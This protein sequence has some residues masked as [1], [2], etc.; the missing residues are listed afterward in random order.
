MQKL[1]QGE[2]SL[3]QV[4]AEIKSAGYDSVFLVT[5][6]HFLKENDLGFLDGLHVSHFI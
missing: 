1:V 3:K 4:T 5:G 6:K 2:N